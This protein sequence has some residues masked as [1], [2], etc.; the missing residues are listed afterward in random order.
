MT[1]LS[2]IAAPARRATPSVEPERGDAAPV[3]AVPFASIL[4]GV[5]AF[6][7]PA[8]SY[9]GGEPLPA[10]GKP[11]PQAIDPPL[12]ANEGAAGPTPEAK[13]GAEVASGRSAIDVRVPM[14]PAA[15][16]N[17]RAGPELQAIGSPG[18]STIATVPSSEKQPASSG[19]VIAEVS[20]RGAVAR[21]GS[22]PEVPPAS[23]K[24]P[25]S[26]GPVN[27]LLPAPGAPVLETPAA[28]A[29]RHESAMPL[30]SRKPSLPPGPVTA[31][32]PAQETL[33]LE[34]GAPTT[35]R[36]PQPPPG[37]QSANPA[38]DPSNPNARFGPDPVVQ[39]RARDPRGS[40]IPAP[41][42]T[43]GRPTE[44]PVA[45][46]PVTPPATT[47]TP[48]PQGPAPAIAALPGPE[49]PTAPAMSNTAPP[50]VSGE[51][52]RAIEAALAR[53]DRAA[54]NEGSPRMLQLRHSEFGAL[55]VRLDGAAATGPAS[56]ASVLTVLSHDPDFATAVRSALAERPVTHPVPLAPE[57]TV[58]ADLPAAREPATAQTGASQTTQANAAQSA[59]AGAG[60]GDPGAGA[61]PR[62]GQPDHAQRT[63]DDRPAAGPRDEPDPLH[64]GAGPPP[65]RNADHALYV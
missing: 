59:T 4:G 17:L 36:A 28:W 64:P 6:A 13:K 2:L 31:A 65:A 29:P 9:Q 48:Q 49:L 25:G 39:L 33:A 11:L 34:P 3:E 45:N 35:L 46:A 14:P 47:Y 54:D 43:E 18:A 19:P 20:A 1:D 32:L 53:L 8:I 60:G 30:A 22:A 26:P 38:T 7:P 41:A 56:T 51:P 42:Q 21:E 10:G 27:A 23:Q 16:P 58:R 52:S 5:L 61:E 24:P 44:L 55:T 40:A 62:D 57:P 63:R 15:A 37:T 50:A 12:P